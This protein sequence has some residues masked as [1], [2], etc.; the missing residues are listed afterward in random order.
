M[1]SSFTFGFSGDDIDPDTADE[2]DRMQIDLPS[3]A[4]QAG[5]QA[6]LIPPQKHTLEEMVK[7]HSPLIALNIA[8]TV[9]LKALLY[10]NLSILSLTTRGKSQS[11]G[12]N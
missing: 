4:Q 6:E 1:A 5:N 7:R 9:A 11:I 2:D 10:S 3:G 8:V 12:L